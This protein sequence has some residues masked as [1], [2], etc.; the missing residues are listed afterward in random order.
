MLRNRHNFKWTIY[1]YLMKMN[2]KYI[3]WEL[4]NFTLFTKNCERKEN[5]LSEV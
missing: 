3:K 2:R 5:V 1:V 4:Y